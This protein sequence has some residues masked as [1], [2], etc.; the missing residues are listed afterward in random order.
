MVGKVEDR[1]SVGGRGRKRVFAR[2][3][4]VAW[5]C[6]YL[7]V[8]TP[9]NYTQKGA[10]YTLRVHVMLSVRGRKENKMQRASIELLEGAL[11]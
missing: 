6:P 2:N 10:P 7:M 4:R 8:K 11:F 5:G 9:V 3:V 1:R